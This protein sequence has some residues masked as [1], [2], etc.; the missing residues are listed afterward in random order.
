MKEVICPH[1]KH[2]VIIEQKPTKRKPKTKKPAVV[3]RSPKNLCV[4]IDGE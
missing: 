2:K 3:K 1:C 4:N